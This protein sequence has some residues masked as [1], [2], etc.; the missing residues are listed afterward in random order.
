[1]RNTRLCLRT[2]IFLLVGLAFAGTSL[3]K[4]SAQNVTLTVLADKHLGRISPYVYGANHGPWALVPPD[5]WPTAKDSGITYLRFPAGDWGDLNDLTPFHIDMFITFA[6]LI[7][8][9][10]S[11]SARLK[12]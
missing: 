4:T 10:P 5:M 11:I 8:A 3:F 12:G 2:A 1:M 6:H 7:H 9:E